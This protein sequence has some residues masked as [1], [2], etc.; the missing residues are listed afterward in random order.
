[1]SDPDSLNR[2]FGIPGIASFD[3]GEG[4]LTRLTIKASSANAEVYVHG[5][6]VTRF[7][8]KDQPPLLFMSKMS[9]FKAGKPI[10]GGVPICFPWFGPKAGDAKAPAHGFARLMEWTVES[11]AQVGTGASVVLS[12]ASNDETKAPWPANFSAKYTVTV[13]NELTLSLAVTNLGDAPVKFE[14][15][16]HSYFTVGDI[17]AI[18]IV[19]LADT[20]Y[21]DKM[22][23][24]APTQQN[25]EPIRFTGETDRVYLSTR[26]TC[27]VNDPVLAR[28]IEIAKS[29]SEATVVWNPWINK[30]KAMADFGDDEWPGMVC[31]E[32]CNVAENAVSLA[33]GATHVMTA[34]IST[35]R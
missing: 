34:M 29:G 13:G 12:L 8:P 31:V 25:D 4:G 22:N 23:S 17:E 6:H 15:A 32:T 16:L 35:A 2:Q 7:D 14:E 18:S 19:G 5:A 28:D 33:P 10:R 20:T 1:M 21:L 30:A 11:V 9:Q 26:A 27:M 24:G 3:D